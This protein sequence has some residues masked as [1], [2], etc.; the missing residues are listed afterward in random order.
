MK[1]KQIAVALASMVLASGTVTPSLATITP[2]PTPLADQP[3]PPAAEPFKGTVEAVDAQK[4]TLT[5]AGKQYHVTEATTLTK[6]GKKAALADIAV[7][8]QVRGLARHGADGKLEATTIM[9]GSTAS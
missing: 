8:E 2:T 6:A 9:V 1:S 7:G 3:Q 5:V 4:N